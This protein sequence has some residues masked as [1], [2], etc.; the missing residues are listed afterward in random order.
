MYNVVTRYNA[1]SFYNI[2][3]VSNTGKKQRIG[4]VPVARPA[5]MHSFGMTQN[6]FI[7]AEFPLV[8]NPISLL[9]WLKP[10]IENFHWQPERGTRIWLIHRGTGEVAAKFETEAFFAFHHVNA[11]EQGDEVVLDIV[12]YK[13]ASIIQSYYLDRIKD[14]KS[15]LPFGNLRRYRLPLMAGSRGIK[16]TYETISDA[17]MELPHIDYNNYNLRADYRFVYSIGIDEKYRQ[18]FYNQLVKLDIQTR[19]KKTWAEEDCF[20]GEPVFVPQPGRTT[21]DGGV[22]LSVVLDTKRGISFLL[23]LNAATFEEISRAEV[24]QPVLVGY[25]GIFLPEQEQP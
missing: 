14:S 16:V 15:E 6:Y 25:H 23:V 4:S 19:E 24:P 9:L 12:A 13:D 22:I 2:H 5:Y 18:G 3:S 11:F 21:E 8:V 17:C 10:Y 20:P 7:L 1:V